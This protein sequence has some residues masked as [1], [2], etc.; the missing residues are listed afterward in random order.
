MADKEKDTSVHVENAVNPVASDL[1]PMEWYILKVASNREESIRE[2]LRRRVVLSGM[3]SYFGE[4]VVPI[5]RVTEVKGGKKRVYKRK[6]YP[7]YMMLQMI[8]TEE[9][10]LVV[11]ETPGIG[12]FTGPDGK[13]TPMEPYEV[14]EML[15]RQ[16]SQESSTP[17]LSIPFA[18]GDTVR[19]HEGMF[20]NFEGE[21]QSIDQATGKVSVH[22]NIFGRSTP[23]EIK[24]WQIDKI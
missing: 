2:G 21:I 16:E 15:R 5:E 10:F 24:Y 8:V 9:T 23:V 19:I 17:K 3:E 22:I 11:R 12:G 18:V 6:L 4:S 7:G 14:D 13:P 20:E 1:P